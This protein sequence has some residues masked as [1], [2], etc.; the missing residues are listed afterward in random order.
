L[1]IARDLSICGTSTEKEKF[2]G[3]DLPSGSHSRYKKPWALYSAMSFGAIPPNEK[4]LH[5]ISKDFINE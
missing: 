2:D 1:T 4:V 5:S 3:R